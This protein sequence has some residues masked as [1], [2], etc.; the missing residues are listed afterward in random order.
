MK[1]NHFRFVYDFCF[2]NEYIENFQ[3]LLVAIRSFQNCFVTARV[4]PLPWE[5]W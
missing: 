5:P 4:A 1:C 3:K 2:K